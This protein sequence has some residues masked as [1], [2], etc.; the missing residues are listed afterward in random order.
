MKKENFPESMKWLKKSIE[1]D[2]SNH[3]PYNGLGNL[4]K[5]L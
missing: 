4:Y 2:P 1:V 3:H 5:R